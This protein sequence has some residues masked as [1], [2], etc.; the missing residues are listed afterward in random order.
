MAGRRREVDLMPTVM[1]VSWKDVDE[2]VDNLVPRIPRMDWPSCIAAVGRGG[3]VPARLLADRLEVKDVRFIRATAYEGTRLK[4]LRFDIPPSL[5]DSALFVDDLVDSG[6]TLA[7]LVAAARYP[8]SRRTAVL[9]RKTTS[10]FA[11]TYW[12]LEVPGHVWVEFPWERDESV[13][14]TVERGEYLEE[15]EP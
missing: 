4:E 2:L 8:Q 15:A 3:M 5:P 13:K 11:P 10:R 1:T 12:A 7:R 6:T 14:S 9:Y